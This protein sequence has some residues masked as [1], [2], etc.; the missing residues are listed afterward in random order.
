MSRKLGTLVLAMGILAGAMGL[1]T[2]LTAH[3]NGTVLMMANNPAPF[4]DIK[5]KPKPAPVQ[6][7]L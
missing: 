2:V 4:P 7:G 5:Q 3:A 6:P 1:K